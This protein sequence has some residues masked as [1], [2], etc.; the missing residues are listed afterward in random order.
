MLKVTVHVVSG[1][2]E[3]DDSP[4]QAECRSRV[5][6]CVDFDIPES[7]IQERPDGQDA[8]Y[9]LGR[10]LKHKESI[11]KANPMS[12][13]DLDLAFR[14]ALSWMVSEDRENSK[15][16]AVPRGTEVGLR[17]VRDRIK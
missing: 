2:Y 1:C 16:P 14:T 17:Y 6:S 4:L 7:G 8:I 15:L 11:V 10:F 13:P 5:D 12:G 3:T 9:A